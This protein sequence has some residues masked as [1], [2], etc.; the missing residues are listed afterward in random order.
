MQL[1]DLQFWRG[2]LVPVFVAVIA[3]GIAWM[4][5]FALILALCLIWN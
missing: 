1:P 2:V 3:A 5:L 4:L